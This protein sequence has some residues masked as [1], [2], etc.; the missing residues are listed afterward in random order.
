MKKFYELILFSSG[1]KDYVESIVKLI[2]ENENY[3]EY[4]LYRQHVSFDEKGEYFKNLNLLNRDIK[5]I[6]IIDDK[7]KNYKYHKSN[8][9]SIKP[10]NGDNE[11]DINILD[12]LGQ[13]LI[14]IRIDVEDSGDIRISLNKEKKNLIYKKVANNSL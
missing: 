7:E 8:G 1:T 5:N 13:I 14:K 4:V 9:I 6:L 2:E 11:N 3:F 10:F 12:L